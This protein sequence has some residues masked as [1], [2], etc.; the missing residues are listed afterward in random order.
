[1]LLDVE[2][3]RHGRPGTTVAED[4]AGPRASEESVPWS[5]TGTKEG[6]EAR[7][8]RPRKRTV[9]NRGADESSR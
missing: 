2:S 9:E 8:E 7:R 1:M 6:N 5:T 4:G 3:M